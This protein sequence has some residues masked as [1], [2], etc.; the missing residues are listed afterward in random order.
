MLRRKNQVMD[1]KIEEL[2]AQIHGIRMK[3]EVD[4]C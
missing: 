1:T 3:M 2:S 4:R